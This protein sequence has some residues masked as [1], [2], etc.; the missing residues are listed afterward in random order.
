MRA[1][2]K[3]LV[4]AHRLMTSLNT[5]NTLQSA[6]IYSGLVAGLVVCSKAGSPAPANLMCCCCC[7]CIALARSSHT[8]AHVAHTPA[9]VMSA[10]VS[11]S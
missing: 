2:D 1:A 7:C 11:R 9:L 5:L 3:P 10:S 8:L 4:P 6:I